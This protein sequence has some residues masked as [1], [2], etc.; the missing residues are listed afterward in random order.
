MA[1]Q[2]R[3]GKAVLRTPKYQEEVITQ[4]QELLTDHLS[5]WACSVAFP[6]LSHMSLLQLRRFAK[7]STVERFRRTTKQLVD[8]IDR[9]AKWV[10]VQRD[11]VDFSP[12]DVARVN[13]FLRTESEAGKA[14][15]QVRGFP[16][17][18]Y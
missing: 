2:L 11:R 13:E 16:V 17:A 5:Q 15:L 14:P 18:S 4:V 1:L 3:A 8:A 7:T 10:G 12:K 9:N 6:E